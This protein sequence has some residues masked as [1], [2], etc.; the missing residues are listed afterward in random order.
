MARAFVTFA[1]PS[2]RRMDRAAFRWW[3]AE[4]VREDVANDNVDAAQWCKMMSDVA[5]SWADRPAFAAYRWEAM[6][7]VQ[8]VRRE[9]RPVAV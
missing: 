2:T 4:V 3:A 8:R 9:N 6:A 5:A 1:C 7:Q